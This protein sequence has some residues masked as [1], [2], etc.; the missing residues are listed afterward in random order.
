MKIWILIFST[1]LFVGGTCLGVAL[2]PKLVPTAKAETKIDSAPAAPIWG[3][4]HN[5]QFSVHRF[6]SELGLSG[7]QDREL[8]LILSDGQEETQALGRAMKA[9]QDKTR[10]RIM[11]LL[12]PEQRTKLD[13]L[14][15]AE[16]Q[17]R[18]DGEISRSVNAYTRILGLDE[19]QAQALK[20]A[21]TDARS[22]R[23]D[24]KRGEDYVQIRKAAREEQNK[25]L[26]KAFSPDQYKR[27]LEVSELDRSER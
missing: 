15:A 20:T 5:P 12:T 16:R 8:D 25:A 2:Q 22:R 27:Y 14:M 26:E 18:S 9:S 19:K 7:E 6:A 1:A 21:M 13:A 4:H 10:D 24:L 17:K 11:T 23:R 3:Q